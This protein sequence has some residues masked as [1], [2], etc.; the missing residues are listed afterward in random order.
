MLREEFDS[1]VSERLYN[2]APFD[3]GDSE[4]PVIETV[5]RVC[6]VSFA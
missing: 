1:L 5:G 6:R 2:G 3:V 4:Y